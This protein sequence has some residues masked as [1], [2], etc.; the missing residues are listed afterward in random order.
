MGMIETLR[1]RRYDR[2]FEANRDANMFRGVFATFAEAAASAP[3]SLPL[4]YDNPQSAAMYMDRTRKVYATDYPVMF[5]LQRL[6]A[7]GRARIYEVGGHV[8]V[9][10]YA[11]RRYLAYPQALRW[12]VHDVPAVMEQGRRLAAEKDSARQLGFSDRFDEAS[13]CEVLLAQGSVQYL[14]ELICDRVAA[15]AARPAHVILNLTPLHERLSYFTLQSVGTAFCPYRVSASGEFLRAWRPSATRSSTSGEPGEEGARSRSTRSTR[16]TATTGSTF[17]GLDPASLRRVRAPAL[18]PLPAAFAASANAQCVVL[19]NPFGRRRSAPTGCCA[20][21]A[22]GWR[23][24]ASRCCDSTTRVRAT[25]TA[26]T[27]R[28]TSGAGWRTCSAPTPRRGARAAC[29][30]ARGSACAWAP[31]SPRSPRREPLPRRA[32]WCCG[33][34]GRRP[35]VP[36]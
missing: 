26:T 12:T 20:C 9:S 14:P 2:E 29:V 32:P 1:R 17:A 16:S 18:R 11:Y 6:F 21:S 34:G 10:Y 15:L 33:T 22:T 8:G 30:P 36:G 3:P 35:R 5:W 23:A 28:P 25:P 27:R 7:E 31:R 13:G 4:G 24:P 19:C